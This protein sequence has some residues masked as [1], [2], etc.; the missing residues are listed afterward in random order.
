M[1]VTYGLVQQ[2]ESGDSKATVTLHVS[3]T[4]DIV[5]R[6]TRRV[7]MLVAAVAGVF[8]VLAIAVILSKTH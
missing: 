7:G 1:P 6:V 5:D 8:S 2:D 3:K 4:S